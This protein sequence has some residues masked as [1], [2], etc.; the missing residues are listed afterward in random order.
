MK[1]YLS[2]LLLLVSLSLL[3]KT[4]AATKLYIVRHAEKMTDNQRKDPL[5]TLKERQGS[6]S[7][8]V[9]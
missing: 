3:L 2:F 1:Q 8:I 6:T 5:L 9:K 7:S 4:Q